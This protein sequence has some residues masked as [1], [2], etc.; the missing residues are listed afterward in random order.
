MR[1][2]LLYTKWD[3]KRKDMALKAASNGLSFILQ[4]EMTDF[5]KVL[6]EIWQGIN[7]N[8]GSHTSRYIT[9]I[10]PN[11]TEVIKLRI[12]DHLSTES[13][14]SDHEITGYPKIQPLIFISSKLMPNLSANS[15]FVW[16]ALD[17][18]ARCPPAEKPITEIAFTSI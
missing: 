8:F 12:S 2:K 11:K 15:L 6:F 4:Y 16:N 14:W 1:D 17:V 18:A 9:F 3:D 13:E 10:P 5:K 7:M